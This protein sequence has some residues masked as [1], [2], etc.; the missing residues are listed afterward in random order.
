MKTGDIVNPW[1]DFV[2]VKKEK[3]GGDHVNDADFPK[4]VKHHHR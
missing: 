2:M 3:G 1:K 4:M